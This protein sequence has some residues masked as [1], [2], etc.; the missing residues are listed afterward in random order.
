[1]QN[2]AAKL[3]EEIPFAHLSFPALPGAN[4]GKWHQFKKQIREQLN[5]LCHKKETAKMPTLKHVGAAPKPELSGSV[6][7]VALV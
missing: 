2:C 6:F 5:N 3:D 7:T 4:I 1:M